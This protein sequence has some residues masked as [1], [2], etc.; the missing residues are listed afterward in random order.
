[1][2]EATQDLRKSALA[3]AAFHSAYASAFRAFLDDA[4][5]AALRA[6]YE[7][8]RDAVSREIGLLELAQA[9]HA[10]LLTA[11][12]HPSE[13]AESRRITGAAA[14][15]LL[16]ALSAYEMVHRGFAEARE[17][18]AFERRQAAMV[19]QLSNLLADASLA[20]H[21]HASI[22]EVLQLVAE[23]ARELTRAA[24][25]VTHARLALARRGAILTYA[26]S[27]P[28]DPGSI[29][30]EAYAV[31]GPGTEPTEVV[32]VDLRSAA[33]EVVAVPLAAL[34]GQTVGV[35]AVAAD[36]EGSFTE[37]DHAVLIHIGQMTAAALERAMRYHGA[38]R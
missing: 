22:E 17:A 2:A 5:E 33:G 34:D 11:L 3:A 26:G 14:D 6:A 28:P 19:R 7:L 15:F 21:A 18:V 37:L 20:L 29:V 10:A 38:L 12:A 13:H 27:P 24:W 16:E 35:L 1:M 9:H 32:N 8:G 23:Q 36:G 31:I 30:D 4:S 25:C